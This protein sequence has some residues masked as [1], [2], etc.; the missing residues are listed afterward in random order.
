MRQMMNTGHPATPPTPV[1]PAEVS[2]T[3][4]A[5]RAECDGPRI[6][7]LP[8]G[9]GPAVRGKLLTTHIISVL[10][11]ASCSVLFAGASDWPRFRGP[12]SMAVSA[13]PLSGPITDIAWKVDLPG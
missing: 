1:L 3:A 8:P 9:E 4:N 13:D 11:V 10:S 5:S 2:M 12:G 6:S 7:P